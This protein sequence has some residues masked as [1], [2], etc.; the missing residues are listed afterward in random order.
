MTGTNSA[1]P[2]E[3]WGHQL[4]EELWPG[5][6]GW[7]WPGIRSVAT[8]TQTS[9]LC[10]SPPPSECVGLPLQPQRQRGLLSACGRQTVPGHWKGSSAFL[11][12][13]ILV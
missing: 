10:Y 2:G 6:K 4:V 8:V 3:Q 1:W 13:L 11:L 5:R 7:G 12:F 9:R